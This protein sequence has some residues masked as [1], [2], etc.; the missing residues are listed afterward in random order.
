M[1]KTLSPLLISKPKPLPKGL[2]Y[3][4]P[5]TDFYHLISLKSKKIVGE[6]LAFPKENDRFLYT[7]KKPDDLVFQ[8]QSLKIIPEEQHNGWG[9][10]L[11]D[12]AKRESFK[13]NCEGRLALVAYNYE[14]S[15]HAFYKKQGLVTKDSKT[16]HILDE[17]VENHWI[18]FH[19]DA[20]PMFL[21]EENIGKFSVKNIATKK[22]NK[23]K[24]LIKNFL[25]LFNLDV[26]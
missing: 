7:D 20:M 21:P 5:H 17:Y 15:P 8:I 12:F 10:F 18:P 23:F 16:N 26:L 24:I 1:I 13:Q 14:R 2:I 6:M 25:N 4:P 22:E 9:K 3:N 11:M 19:W